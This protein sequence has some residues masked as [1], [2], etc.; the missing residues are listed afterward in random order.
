METEKLGS[1]FMKVV[2]KIFFDL[3]KNKLKF[4]G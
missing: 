3:E 2:N 4:L 1:D